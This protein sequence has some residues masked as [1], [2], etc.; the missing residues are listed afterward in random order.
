[1]ILNR[2]GTGV[3]VQDPRAPAR[4]CINKYKAKSISPDSLKFSKREDSDFSVR[5]GSLGKWMKPHAMGNTK[6]AFEQAQNVL[7]LEG[8]YHSQH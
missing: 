7:N 8:C 4:A 1:M 6:E 5:W 3:P 2:N